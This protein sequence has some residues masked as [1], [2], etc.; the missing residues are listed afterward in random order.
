VYIKVDYYRNTYDES[1]GTRTGSEA[2]SSVIWVMNV[3]DGSYEKTIETPLYESNFTEGSRRVTVK[4]PYSLLG[5]AKDER[6]FLSFPE[7]DGY[8][9][10]I[11]DTR[12]AGGQQYRGFINV[13]MD[14]IQF[15]AFDL[16]G[17]GILSAMLVG[18]WDVKFVWWHTDKFVIKDE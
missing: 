6:V 9:I 5:V 17:D 10:L 15:N 2:D 3:E 1:T 12:E 18:D 4:I 7:E 8:T 13:N 14:E 11:L 16:S